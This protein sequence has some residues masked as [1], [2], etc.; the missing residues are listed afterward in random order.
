MANRLWIRAGG[1]FR[2]V[3]FYTVREFSAYVGV[4]QNTIW[5]WVHE[6]L[7]AMVLGDEAATVSMIPRVR[8]TRWV[9]NNKGYPRR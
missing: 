5:R 4:T 1:R 6:G 7:P 8:G 9:R 3:E 2:R